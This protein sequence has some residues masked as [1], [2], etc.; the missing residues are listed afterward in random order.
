VNCLSL[1]LAVAVLFAIKKKGTKI[2]RFYFFWKCVEI[3][4]L[5][6]LEILTLVA[7]KKEGVS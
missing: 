5:P 1:A 2:L 7:E 3:F 4:L 6:L